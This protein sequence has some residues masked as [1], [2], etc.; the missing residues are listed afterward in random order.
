MVRGLFITILGAL[1]VVA[2]ASYPAT[3]KP[4][5]ID[6]TQ[7]S[8][9]SCQELVQLRLLTETQ[10]QTPIARQY[11][12]AENDVAKYLLGLF[13]WPI[14]FLIDRDGGMLLRLLPC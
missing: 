5:R 6:A 8:N 9:R 13:F 14:L 10:M 11:V 4:Q 12:R 3:I 2:C 1:A 7:F